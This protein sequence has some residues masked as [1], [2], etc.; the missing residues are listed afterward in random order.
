MNY[1]FMKNLKFSHFIFTLYTCSQPEGKVCLTCVLMS[2]TN[3]KYIKLHWYLHNEDWRTKPN[4]EICQRNQLQILNKIFKKIRKV[5]ET[6][7]IFL[8]TLVKLW[9]TKIASWFSYNP[10]SV[11]KIVYGVFLYFP[12][13]LDPYNRHLKLLYCS[14]VVTLSP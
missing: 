5:L 6:S 12:R 2:K 7:H 10:T 9:D 4:S 14:Y 13:L 3:F 1:L 11:H 8:E